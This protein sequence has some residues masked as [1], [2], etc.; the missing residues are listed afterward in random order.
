MVSTLLP[1]NISND[2]DVDDDGDDN[3]PFK[4]RRKFFSQ[5]I[6]VVVVFNIE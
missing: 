4:I 3:D 5:L 1:R 6:V 2:I